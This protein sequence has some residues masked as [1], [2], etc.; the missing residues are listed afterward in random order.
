MMVGMNTEKSSLVSVIN[1]LCR[2][3]YFAM[4]I[5]FQSDYRK[6]AWILYSLNEHKALLFYREHILHVYCFLP[7]CDFVILTL[8]KDLFL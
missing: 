3:T 1:Y 4:H 7:F 2:L 8:A 6:L 5:R